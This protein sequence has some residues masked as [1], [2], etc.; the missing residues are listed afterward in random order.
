MS[1]P[2]FTDRVLEQA[3]PSAEPMT[4]NG[5]IAKSFILFLLLLATAAVSWNVTA[6]QGPGPAMIFLWGGM[7]GGLVVAFATIFK[8]QWSPVTAPL[9]SL[10]QGCVLGTISLLFATKYQG[11]V[12]QAIIGTLA[13]FVVML[14]I[15][16]SG[17]IKVTQ[18]F[19]IGV[20]AATGGLALGYIVIMV[21]NLFGVK[22]AF[23]TD[24]SPLGYLISIVAIVLASLNL[25]LD[26]DFIQRGAEEQAPKYLEWYAGFGLIMTL[27]W[28]YLEM[29]RLLGRMRQ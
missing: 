27:V 13:V 26:F 19:A 12:A 20:A 24:N 29:L 9:Y 6:T 10:L 1:N 3:G 18:K 21:L 2:A 7:I 14:M 16:R 23:M 22:T 5:S 25:V 11:I 8:P 28:L 17:L 4:V 15:Y